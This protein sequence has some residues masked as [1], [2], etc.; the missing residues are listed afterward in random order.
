M[1]EDEQSLIDLL[2][3][4]NEKDILE[5]DVISVLEIL[6]LEEAVPAL[7]EIAND[8]SISNVLRR[9]ARK[10]ISIIL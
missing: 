10:A 9:R 1:T 2:K 3:T 6:F 5:S 7:E 4:K 8:P